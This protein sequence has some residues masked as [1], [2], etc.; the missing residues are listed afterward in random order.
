M[1]TKV[2]EVMTTEVKVASPGTTFREIVR[3]LTSLHISALP[4]VDVEGMVV[5]VV[6]EADLML[7][8]LFG[9]HPPLPEPLLPR[10]EWGKLDAAI[11]ADLMSSPAITIGAEATLAQAAKLMHDDQVKRLPVVDG[12]G[13]LVGIVTRGDLLSV[14]LRPDADIRHEVI[15]EVVIRTLWMDPGTLEVAVAGGVVTLRGLVDRRSDIGIL[16]GLIRGLDGV[17]SVLSELDFKYDDVNALAGGPF[18]TVL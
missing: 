8:E 5:G 14:F 7:K 12:D 17:V 9:S 2:A 18:R 11:A 6:S 13:R 10:R 16:T 4:V 3:T 15:E 1:K